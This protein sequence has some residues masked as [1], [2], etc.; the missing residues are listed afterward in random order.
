M[1]FAARQSG[2]LPPAPD[3]DA[4]LCRR[5]AEGDRGAFSLLVEAHGQ[6]LRAFLTHL[7]GADLAD[8][9][10]QESF[11]KAWRSLRSFRGDSKFS[12]WLCAIGWRL[13]IDQRRRQRSEDR[14]REA[15]AEL[16]E[17]AAAPAAGERLDLAR[18]LARLEPVE[19]AAL[20]LCEGHGWSHGEAAVI[21]RMP[22]GTLKG[23]VRRAKKKCREYLG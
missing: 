18:A 22:L 7:A 20:V 15:A 23:T 19:R 2:T 10:A 14:K 17:T 6:R 1:G 12:S 11:V 5:A 16:A 13:F 9:L 8:E 3:D 4:M 21:L